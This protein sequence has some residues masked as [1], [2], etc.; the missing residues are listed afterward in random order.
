MSAREDTIRV[1]ERSVISVRRDHRSLSHRVP[2]IV[3]AIAKALP[4]LLQQ[5]NW[6]ILRQLSDPSGRYPTDPPR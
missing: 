2:R 1:S 5:H 6:P 4:E 3:D